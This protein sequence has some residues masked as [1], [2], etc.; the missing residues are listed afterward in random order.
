MIAVGWEGN[1]DNMR[2]YHGSARETNK[3]AT[4]HPNEG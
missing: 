3:M 2:V 1:A 4:R